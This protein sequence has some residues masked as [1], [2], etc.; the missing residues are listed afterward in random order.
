MPVYVDDGRARYRGMLMAHL[1]GDEADLHVM[2]ARIGL[3]REWCHRGHYNLSQTLRAKAVARCAI[4]ISRKTAAVMMG[5]ARAGL[6]MG[7]PATCL[8]IAAQRRGRGKL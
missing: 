7:T 1:I 5:N 3:R 8:A 4:E 2:A 6:P